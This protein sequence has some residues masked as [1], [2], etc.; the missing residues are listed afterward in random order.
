MTP[1]VQDIVKDMVD[2]IVAEFHPRRVYLFGSHAW[3]N[4]SP[5]SDI[6]LMVVVDTLSGS[7]A[8]MAS[9]A[10]GVL[11]DRTRI[12]TDILFRSTESFDLRA[13]HPSTLEHKVVAEGI[14]LYG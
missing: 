2:R 12:P 7:P 13:A 5:D 10:Y 14:L 3:G 1:V 4:P 6:D 11:P 9:R 8:Q